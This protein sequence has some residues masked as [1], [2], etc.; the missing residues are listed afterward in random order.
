MDDDG[1]RR[2]SCPPPAVFP[3]QNGRR[4]HPTA[5]AVIGIRAMT[6]R[7][8]GCRALASLGAPLAQRLGRLLGQFA[9]VCAL[10]ATNLTPVLL[11]SAGTDRKTIGSAFL[12]LAGGGAVARVAGSR[13]GPRGCFRESRCNRGSR[14]GQEPYLATGTS[15]SPG[16]SPPIHL[17]VPLLALPVGLRRVF[18]YA[19]FDL[20]AN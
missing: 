12:E 14:M 1:L 8:F 6:Q 2:G 4:P 19:R 7:V 16:G 15:Y 3:Q 17:R 5:M 10:A 13:T 11:F 18:C 20:C 9:L